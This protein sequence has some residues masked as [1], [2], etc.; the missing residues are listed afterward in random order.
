VL[1]TP[2][3]DGVATVPKSETTACRQVFCGSSGQIMTHTTLPALATEHARLPAAYEAA[4][5][6]LATC[7]RMDECQNW[8][9][10]AEALASYA[11]QAKDET[12]RK[13]ADRIQARA[14]NRCGELL[15]AVPS[16]RGA[17]QNIQEG[18]LPKVTRTQAAEDAGLSEFQRK[19]ALRVAAVPATQFEAL[20][21]SDNPPTVTQL[22]EIGKKAKPLVDLGD[23]SPVDYALAT[24]AQ[25]A[26][27]SFAAFC[28]KHDAA[29]VAQ[30]FK[31]H[32]VEGMRRFVSAVDGWL[33]TFVVNLKG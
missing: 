32:E 19:I 11:M 14:I 9:N 17:N 16:A 33:D 30:A 22:A 24:S 28:E 6:A 8:A 25:G 5:T 3:R 1:K 2:A 31:P 7:S 13:H 21:E 18:T 4:R 10:K 26:L 29:R 15:R 12:L 20:V 27:R 23:I